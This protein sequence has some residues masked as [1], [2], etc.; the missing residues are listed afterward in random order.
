MNAIRCLIFAAITCMAACGS[1]T[2]STVSAQ[3]AQGDATDTAS[4]M[5]ILGKRLALI[6]GVDDK[7]LRPVVSGAT[8]R[9]TVVLPPNS[10]TFLRAVLMAKGELKSPQR[11][12]W[13][14][15]GSRTKMSPLPTPSVVETAS[16]FA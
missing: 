14:N 9:Y 5:A 2:E 10:E 4:T 8:V 1:D 6:T 3:L 13:A 7:S 16:M 12:A 15:L 11:T